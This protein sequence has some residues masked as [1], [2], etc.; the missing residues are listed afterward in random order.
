[1]KIWEN[2]WIFSKIKHRGTKNWNLRSSWLFFEKWRS[3]VQQFKNFIDR[4]L[5]VISGGMRWKIWKYKNPWFFLKSGAL[6]YVNLRILKVLDFSQKVELWGIKIL[7][8]WKYKKSWNMCKSLTFHER[9]SSE[10]Q[11]WKKCENPWL[12]WKMEIWSTHLYILKI[13][14]FSQ[15]VE[16][17]IQKFEYFKIQKFENLWFFPKSGSLR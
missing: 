9:C 14:D 16:P 11:K 10:L 3:D 8:F 5:F 1:M 4:R 12:L 7:K 2:P 15:K 6:K 17:K 13:L